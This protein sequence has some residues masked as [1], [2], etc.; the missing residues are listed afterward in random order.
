MSKP[1]WEEQYATSDGL[2]T[3]GGGKPT[4]KV[5]KVASQMKKGS[6]VIEFGCGAGRD[7]LYLAENGFDVTSVDISKTGISKLIEIAEKRCLQIKAKV[8]DM[9]DF[10]FEGKYDLV[11]AVGSLHLIPRSDWK[12]LIKKVKEHTVV[13]GFNIMTGFTDQVQTPP[14]MKP[15]FVGLFQE[16]EL[17]EIYDD[18]DILDKHSITFTDNHG[19]GLSHTHSTHGLLAKKLS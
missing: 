3:F 2:K 5:I 15:F 16:D 12:K 8:Q 10:H 17:F 1:F 19:N 7:A 14:D 13:N 9:R 4:D 18:W 6:R 11:I